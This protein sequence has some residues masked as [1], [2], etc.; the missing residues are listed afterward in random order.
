MSKTQTEAERQA[1]ADGLPAEVLRFRLE[2]LTKELDSIQGAIRKIDD[3]GS[4]VKNWAILTWTG[5][6]AGLLS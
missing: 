2:V 6:I 3:I 5:S 4:A 1:A